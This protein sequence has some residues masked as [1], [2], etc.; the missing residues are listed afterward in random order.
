MPVTYTRVAPD[1]LFT[2]TTWSP[3]PPSSYHSTGT[4]T[5][6]TGIT[7]T[8]G[9]IDSLFHPT[10]QKVVRTA[11]GKRFVVFL[12]SDTGGN[13]DPS[14]WQLWRSDDDGSSW[15]KM[16]DSQ[17]KGDTSYG[18]SPAIE[19]DEN[20]N[21]YLIANDYPRAG[22]TFSGL[23]MYK[24]LASNNYSTTGV[25]PTTISSGGTS[26]GKWSAFL[27]QG[28]KWIWVALWAQGSA[29][30]NLFAFDYAGTQQF[31]KQMFKVFTKKW[32]PTSVGIT[33]KHG[34]PAY[35]AVWVGANGTIYL[36][37]TSMACEGGD[38]TNA[39][40]SY[41]DVR[42]VYSTDG[43]STWIGPTNGVSGAVSTRT[44]PL[45]GD[46]SGTTAETAFPIVKLSDQTEFIP[47]SDPN[48][49][50]NSGNKFNMSRLMHMVAN[51]GAV[52]FYYESESGDV[53]V[54][55]H[56]VYARFDMTTHA[57]ADSERR[58]PEFKYDTSVA[59]DRA[60]LQTGQG[61][62]NYIMDTTQAG[63]LYFVS[64]TSRDADGTFRIIRSDDGGK[65]W[66]LYATSPANSI[67]VG[68]NGLLLVQA[69]RWVQSDGTITGILQ[70][71]DAPYT[72]YTFKVT[73]N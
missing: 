3:S 31:S 59:G 8:T 17:A 24:F 21:L 11:A 62:G 41:Y 39:A 6:S 5:I 22:E 38:F 15:S 66:W 19:I 25:T 7:N 69:Y 4:V 13:H 56:H 54:N 71:A 61:G 50:F 46:D 48:Y 43:G 20:E 70:L 73:P 27:D 57:L 18:V 16:W 45:A 52:H 35:P 63:R 26:S 1:P 14:F 37:W 34:E 33:D 55:Q 65:S 47:A 30:S 2:S 68:P 36:A 9:D 67:T 44:L 42:M 12:S 60:G 32:T 64:A 29:Q 40:L 23:K 49:G 58:S 10:T 72:I 28:R 51:N 53:R